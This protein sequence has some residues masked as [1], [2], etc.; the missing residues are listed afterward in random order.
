MKYLLGSDI[1]TS[2]TKT[3]L[4]DLEGRAVASH[5]AEYPL[6]QPQN[7]W[8]EQDPE[9]WW[10]GFVEGVK[11]VIAESG[12]DASDI[13]G[14]G[15][16]GQM[17]GLVMLGK[18]DE[19]LRRSII[20]CDQRTAKE[21]AF[22]EETVGRKRLIEITANPA[23]TGFT[24]SKIL[25][26]MR[27]E[28]EVYE[29][30]VKIMLPKD[31]VRYRLT[32]EFATEVSD[33]SGMQLMDVAG[34]CWSDE[35]LSLLSIDKDLLGKMYESPDVTGRVSESAANLTGL[36]KGTP[37]AGGAG[38]NA[39]A[40]IGAGVCRQGSAFNTI[41][42]SAVIY[43][44]SDKLNIDLGGRVHSLCASV[45]GKWTVMSCTQ[46]AGI[47]LKWLRDTCCTAEIEEAAKLGIDPYVIM[48]KMAAEI[49]AGADKLIY[50]PYL[51]GERSPHPDSDCRGVFF[52]LSAM[53]TRAHLIRSVLEGVAFSQRECMDVFREMGVPVDDMTVCG[54]GGRSKL[55]RQILS[56]VYGCNISVLN[57]DEGGA[58]GAALL[59]GVGAGA[60]E[61]VEQACEQV[62]SK[63][64]AAIPDSIKSAEYEPYFSL[65]K[66]LY[67]SLKDD[68]VS[69]ANI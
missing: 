9:D 11:A 29:K 2:G 39:A 61:S 67:L 47:S 57:A 63:R 49:P 68:F 23:M 60:F 10:N 6:Y 66:K 7:G 16:S 17:H 35:L 48:D 15:L 52:G 13:G 24:A 18:N 36:A 31:Y 27:N 44:V 46:A 40:A 12:A 51:M 22:M 65:Y 14:V 56:D 53:H 34:R 32:G 25:W 26:V 45:P 4:F 8:A 33:A 43:A 62:V 58:L 42:S 69:L 21:C 55:W 38:D 3:V 54:G 41:G 28:P 20:W 59:A 5:T 50:L 19:V 30:C 1:G 37:V 64:V